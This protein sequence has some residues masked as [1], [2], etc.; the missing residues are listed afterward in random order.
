MTMSS[1]VLDDVQGFIMRTYAMPALRVF[2]LKVEHAVLAG[3]FL[4]ALVSGDSAVPKLTTAAPWS[5]KPDVCVNI[6]F[7][8]AGLAALGLAGD[9]LGSFPEEFAQGAVSR[10]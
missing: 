7:T 4:A 6:G 9:G 1:V 2:V 8:H 10:A 5:A 3:R